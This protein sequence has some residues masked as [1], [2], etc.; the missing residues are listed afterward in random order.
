MYHLS[1]ARRSPCAMLISS[2]SVTRCRPCAMLADMDES[3]Y[4]FDINFDSVVTSQKSDYNYRLI[5]Q[6]GQKRGQSSIALVTR[7]LCY[8][9]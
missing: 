4:G 8:V 7:V 9:K 3:F 6:Y 2:Q 1:V 5:K